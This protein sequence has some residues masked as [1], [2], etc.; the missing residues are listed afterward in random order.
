MNQ[1]IG[2]N[3][4]MILGGG[5]SSGISYVGGERLKQL[6][7]PIET[8]LGGANGAISGAALGAAGSAIVTLANRGKDIA[9]VAEETS[10]LKPMLQNITGKHLLPVLGTAAAF[11]AMGALIRFSQARR[12]NEWS[13]RHYNFLERQAAREYNIRS[14]MQD[15]VGGFA[16]REMARRDKPAEEGMTR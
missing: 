3:G 9:G 11:G 1:T 13:E 4:R 2:G 8:L 14:N 10:A 15:H 12:H 7:V 6:D 16:D 5:E